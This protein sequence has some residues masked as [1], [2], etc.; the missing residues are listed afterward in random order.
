M[1]FKKPSQTYF[2]NFVRSSIKAKYCLSPSSKTLVGYRD[3]QVITSHPNIYGKISLRKKGERGIFNS[4]FL[5]S[6]V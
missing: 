5:L 3:V 1:S 4:S 2:D 6:L